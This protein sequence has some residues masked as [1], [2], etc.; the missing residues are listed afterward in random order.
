M[1]QGGPTQAQTQSVPQYLQP[2]QSG[3]LQYAQ[4][5]AIQP[6]TP[7]TGPRVAEQSPLYAY[8]VSQL[9]NQAPSPYTD[10]AGMAA[11]G[12]LDALR[13]AGKGPTYTEQYGRPTTD[14]WIQ[15]GIA[16]A[17]MNPYTQGVLDIQTREANLQADQQLQK[18]RADAAARGAFGGSRS[19]IMESEAARNRGQLL[20][21]IYAKGLNE[22]YSQGRAQFNA[23]EQRE[24]D[25]WKAG[26][27][28]WMNEQNF[29]VSKANAMQGLAGLLASVGDKDFNTN[30]QIL[31]DVM[32]AGLA[33]EARRQRELDFDYQD[34]QRQRDY[35]WEQLNKYAS[36]VY[37]NPFRASDNQSYQAPPNWLTQMAGI[38][39]LLW[40]GTK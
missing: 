18:M 23:D 34:F 33:D 28:Q 14:I 11:A 3:L 12:A 2:Y 16:S 17:Y 38:G 24:L 1:S 9:T 27:Q 37:G 40:G 25:A 26:A 30:R 10:A 21:D 7:Y 31:Q 39:S 32:N 36:I 15:P 6:Y 19:A 29:D 20:S 22:A 5:A 4:Q 35:P 13:D 8:G